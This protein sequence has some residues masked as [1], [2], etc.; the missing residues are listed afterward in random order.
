MIDYHPY[1]V[2][3]LSGDIVLQAEESCRYPPQVELALLEAGYIVERKSRKPKRERR[4]ANEAAENRRPLPV[5]RDAHKVY[6]SGNASLAD[7]YPG[8]WV[9][10]ARR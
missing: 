5:L 8:L 9:Q 7:R 1:I 6:Q 4:C 3:S 2:T 10:P